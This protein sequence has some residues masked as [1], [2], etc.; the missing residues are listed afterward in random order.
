MT[1]RGNHAPRRR[2]RRLTAAPAPEAAT[3]GRQYDVLNR[4]LLEQNPSDGLWRLVNSGWAAEHLPELPALAL[5]QDPIHRHKD[6]LAHTIKVTAQ[7]P[8][9]L[10]V[11]L[12]ALFH[13]IGKPRTRSYAQGKVTF[14]G[15]E[16]AGARMTKPR[17]LALGYSE[18]QAAE[19][20]H[21]VAMSGRF[22]G[23]DQGWTDSAVRR[24]VR[25]AG[26]L[27]EDLTAL[28]RADCTSRHRH[29]V[30]ALRSSI[31]RFQEHIARV[32]RA[33]EEAA[34]RPE[35]DGA[36]VM[37]H[38]GIEPGPAV[39]RAMSFL[40]DLRRSDGLIGEDEVLRRLEAW[41]AVQT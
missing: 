29:K 23:Y 25:E 18:E 28:V 31:R 41:W 4:V 7:T 33:D 1:S 32:A 19:V 39:G 11:R 21:L 34:L 20:A 10:R 2:V 5:E 9:R 22:R 14:I 16:S 36:K 35:I 8:R 15:H 38:L 3:D 27:L 40:L 6:V 26:P 30:E 24:Y 37:T 17:M 13:D 12:A